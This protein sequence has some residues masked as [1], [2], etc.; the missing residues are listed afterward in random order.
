MFEDELP[1]L[2]PAEFFAADIS[3]PYLAGKWEADIVKP[4]FRLPDT[5]WLLGESY[6]HEANMAWN[7][8][9][10]YFYFHMDGAFQEPAYPTIT[11]GDSIELF[12]DTR[13]LGKLSYIHKYA[14]HFYVLPHAVEG[15]SKGEITRFRTEEVHSLAE[16]ESI[17]LE[18]KGSGKEG[19]LKIH[20]PSEVLYGFDPSAFQKI[21]FS[22]RVNRSGHFP[23]HFMCSGELFPLDRDPSLW[24]VCQL[25]G[26]KK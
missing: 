10:L 24:T 14:H 21:A 13:A 25:T 15:H 26:K 18:G 23:E 4:Q 20:L 7:E 1:S 9:G 3:I 16:P 12:I 17:V 5:S 6:S 11:E 22:Y 19:K 2:K 8:A